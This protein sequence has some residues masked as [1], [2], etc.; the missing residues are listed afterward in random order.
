ME[1]RQEADKIVAR[2]R[3]TKPNFSLGSHKMDYLSENKGSMKQPGVAVI[4]KAGID[5]HKAA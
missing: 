2:V 1:R 3:P 5:A 4:D